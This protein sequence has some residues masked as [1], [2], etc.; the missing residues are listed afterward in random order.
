MRIVQ[1][2]LFAEQLDFYVDAA[3]AAH[4]RA[5]TW[6]IAEGAERL[7]A[8]VGLELIDYETVMCHPIADRVKV[9]LRSRAWGERWK[10][11]A[12]QA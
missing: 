6:S 11:I 4:A 10:R 9:E 7:C 1:D 2:L 5:G 3:A 12:R 8:L